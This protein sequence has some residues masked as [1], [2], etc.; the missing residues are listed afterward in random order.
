MESKVTCKT[1]Q[2]LLYSFRPA[3]QGNFREQPI[4]L[5]FH[6]WSGALLEDMSQSFPHT[7]PG[8]NLIWLNDIFGFARN[9]SWWLGEARNFFMLDLIDALVSKLRDQF[10]MQGDLY[11]WGS[12]MGGFGALFHGLRLKTKGICINVPQT[13]LVG[14]EYINQPGQ[15]PQITTIWDESIL[16]IT[17]EEAQRR[18]ATGEDPT[19]RYADATCFLDTENPTS[20]PLIFI[21]QAR[22]DGNPG[23]F[24]E[25]CMYLVD[26]L[27]EAGC[28][29]E[30]FVE[31]KKGHYIIRN[32]DQ[33]IELFEKYQE[34]IRDPLPCPPIAQGLHSLPTVRFAQPATR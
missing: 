17:W 21:S 13:R 24:T 7:A 14:T 4:L 22:F 9:G 3:T 26:R 15:A 12:S 10:G 23:Y 31:P 30:L 33:G 2:E 27:V 1:G 34:S 20:N 5:I 29:F 18:I 28:N 6:G 19:L 11:T 32:F 25:H 16:G 8:W